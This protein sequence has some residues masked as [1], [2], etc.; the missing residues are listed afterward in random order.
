M[1]PRC[2]YIYPDKKVNI[3]F[4]FL[5]KCVSKIIEPKNCIKEIYEVDSLEFLEK[6]ENYNDYDLKQCLLNNINIYKVHAEEK[7]HIKNE[8]IIKMFEIFG[9]NVSLDFK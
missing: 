4:N 6:F 5:L 2:L 1:K 7:H 8:L 9:Y 3:L